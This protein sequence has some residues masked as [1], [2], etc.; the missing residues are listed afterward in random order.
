[1]RTLIGFALIMATAGCSLTGG[2]GRSVD[3]RELE[4][5]V[6]QPT[7]V[8]RVFVRFDEGRQARSDLPGGR[9]ADSSRFGREHGWKARYRRG[10]TPRTPGPLVIESRADLFDA[11]DGAEDELE[12]TRLDVIEGQVPWQE[13]DAPDLGDE[14]IAATFLQGSGA[15][16]VRSYLIAWRDENVAA[17][18]LVNGFDRRLVVADAVQLAE[19]QASRI[20]AAAGT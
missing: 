18:V 1:M 2:D 20:A 13:I 14:A 16:A 8:P 12:A 4:N 11:K 19:K 10:G 6:L 9:R 15:A 5:L 17:S 3:A 7:D